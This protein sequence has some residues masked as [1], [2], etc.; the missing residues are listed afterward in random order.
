MIHPLSINQGT[1]AH[2]LHPQL[3]RVSC[4]HH[5][6]LR[7]ICPQEALDIPLSPFVLLNFKH[8]TRDLRAAMLLE[9]FPHK[10]GETSSLQ[11]TDPKTDTPHTPRK[12][13]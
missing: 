13:H 2:H 11:G 6:E 5:R 7:L 4:S 8:F 9:S 12:P 1:V 10:G 3:P